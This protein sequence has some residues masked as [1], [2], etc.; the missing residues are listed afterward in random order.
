[1]KI[2]INYFDLILQE[3]EVYQLDILFFNNYNIL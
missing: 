2:G 3:L 1:M